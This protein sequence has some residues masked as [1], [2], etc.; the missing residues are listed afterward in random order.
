MNIKRIDNAE[1][2]NALE[3]IWDGL[4]EK[5]AVAAPFMTHGW[6]RIWWRWLGG[7][8]ELFVLVAKSDNEIVGIAPMMI[9]KNKRGLKRL[10]FMID[11]NGA[12]FDFIVL[13][14]F[15]PRFFEVISSYLYEHSGLWDE[16]LL[17]YYP[18][19][20]DNYLPLKEIFLK[21]RFKLCEHTYQA[22]YIEFGDSWE[23]YLSRRSKTFR[24]KLLYT[25]HR[26]ERESLT[27][28]I[29]T[30]DD[31][32]E[33]IIDRIIKVEAKTWKYSEG[34]ALTST[35]NSQNF[36]RGLIEYA[37]RSGSFF[38]T[39]MEK[40]DHPI[41]YNLNWIVRDTVFGLKQSY[42]EEFRNFGPGKVLLAYT[43]Q[44]SIEKGLRYLEMGKTDDFKQEWSGKNY[45]HSRIHIY[46]KG[47]KSQVLYHY[48]F[49]LKRI[50]KRLLKGGDFISASTSSPGAGRH[51]LKDTILKPFFELKRL[52]KG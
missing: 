11:E 41:A 47:L 27:C 14:E 9:S 21:N 20:S 37:D 48:N 52:L 28:R 36:Y 12:S 51:R 1:G 49:N 13:P 18:C 40:D 16:C 25:L 22:S 26:A 23:D 8:R 17:N 30:S 50:G 43:I 19:F 31:V 3:P 32:I 5:N 10:E 2:L 45:N 7:D 38:L 29:I 39:L 46:H 15:R 4:L 34:S 33:D 44:K 35:E 42:D 24:K 6:V